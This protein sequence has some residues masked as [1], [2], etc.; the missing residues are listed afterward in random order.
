MNMKQIFEMFKVKVK[1]KQYT[2]QRRK[3]INKSKREDD[4]W[5]YKDGEVINT[6]AEWYKE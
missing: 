1:V 4:K 6:N 5:A 3:R 2:E